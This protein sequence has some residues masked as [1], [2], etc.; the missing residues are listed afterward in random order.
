MK[1]NGIL[2]DLLIEAVRDQ[3]KFDR[4]FE[5]WKN[6]DQNLSLELAEFLFN[7]HLKRS[8]GFKVT[9]PNVRTFLNRFDGVVGNF[10]QFAPNID[11]DDY[12]G[13]EKALSKIENF[14]LEQI[15]FLI[16]EFIDLPGQQFANVVTRIAAPNQDPNPQ[17][18]DNSKSLW[19]GKNENLIIDEGNFR[20]YKIDTRQKSIDF[21][22]YEGYI[23]QS[24]PYR[25]SGKSHMQWCTTRHRVDSNMYAGYRDRRTFYFIIDE[26]KDPDIEKDININQYYLSALQYATDTAR[27][28]RF[29]LTSILN[30]GSD[31]DFS[32]S[33]LLSVYPKLSNHLDKIIKKDYNRSYEISNDD[34]VINWITEQPGEYEFKRR[35]NRE[36]KE[37]VD[38]RKFLKKKDSWLSMDKPLRQTYINYTQGNDVLERFSDEIIQTILKDKD[39]K[40]RFMN[41]LKLLNF[42]LADILT[43]FFS[44]DYEVIMKNIK[45]EYIVLAM[46]KSQPRKYGIYDL[47]KKEFLE[48][49]GNMYSPEY[50]DILHKFMIDQSGN[51][52]TVR[53]HSKTNSI[54]N[55][56]FFTIVDLFN[57]NDKM[58]PAIFVSK[59][60][61]DQ[62]INDG[63]LIDDDEIVT[64]DKEV[65]NIGDIEEDS[66]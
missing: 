35:S 11:R 7:E 21:G 59:Q 15:K 8:S 32:D 12:Q 38:R 31:P 49:D 17:I 51:N 66:Y 28:I 53:G 27:G 47:N 30:D 19:Y 20:V 43:H 55:N 18:I 23:S 39:D 64:S 14:N 24:E 56:S 34:D 37:Y 65:N 13:L 54:D 41:R 61:W 45:N 57:E 58:A 9:N 10:N 44:N 36:K 5:I 62:L 52:Y 22:Y 2:S 25:S 26:S 60:Q 16:G 3:Q 4:I 1:F 6:Q 42:N 29:K 33:K 63:A 50:N 40:S 46:T 48:K